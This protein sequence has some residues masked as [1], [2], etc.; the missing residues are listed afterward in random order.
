MY[1]IH[2]LKKYDIVELHKVSDILYKCGKDM[3]LKYDLHHWDNSRLKN[4][5][6]MILCAMKNEIYLVYDDRTPVATFQTQVKGK[7]LLF[8]KLATNPEFAGGGIGTFCM[9][10]LEKIGRE[11]NCKEIICE[12]YDKS[13]HALNFYKRRGY[14]V[15]GTTETIKYNE[16]KLRKNL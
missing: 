1:S 3:A 8:Q 14:S 16:L 15:Y 13:E 12:V 7:S 5:A 11:K 6:V 2:K 4:V 9:D 10:E